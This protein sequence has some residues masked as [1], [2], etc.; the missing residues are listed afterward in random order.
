MFLKLYDT[1]LRTNNDYLALKIVVI[2][3]GSSDKFFEK[4]LIIYK[5]VIDT[6]IQSIEL[7]K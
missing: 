3:F 1:A 7:N 2:Y 6:N 5:K 4:E